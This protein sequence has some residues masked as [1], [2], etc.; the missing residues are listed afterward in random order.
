MKIGCKLGLAALAALWLAFA[1]SAAPAEDRGVYCLF[2][3]GTETEKTRSAVETCMRKMEAAFK[4]DDSEFAKNNKGDFNSAGGLTELNGRIKMKKTLKGEDAS[5]QNIVKAC[6]EL[7]EAAGPN[8]AVFVY[9]M[10][11]GS[12]VKGRDGKERHGLSPIA[13][14][15][16]NLNNKEI[17][18]ARGTIMKTIKSKKHR[19]DVLLTDSCA[20]PDRADDLSGAPKL[21]GGAKSSLPCYLKSFLLKAEG[22]LNVN[23]ARPEM[24]GKRGESSRGFHKKTW[25]VTPGAYDDRKSYEAYGGSVFLNA[26]LKL[27]EG[28][29]YSLNNDCS[30]DK[31]FEKLRE[32]QEFEYYKIRQWL[33]DT[34]QINSLRGFMDQTTQTAIRFDDD[35]VPYASDMEYRSKRKLGSNANGQSR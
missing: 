35:S 26:F 31:F 29:D 32:A 30:V 22:E 19:L 25:T 10:C 1:S 28:R 21:P 23:A 18:I 4:E 12:V 6:K 8:D 16:G 14:D 27:A 5:P 24:R 2:V 34:G 11:H 3:W 9:I 13:K 33:A 20:V 15:P 17:G 7:A